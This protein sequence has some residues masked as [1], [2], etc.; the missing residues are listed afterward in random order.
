MHILF[1]IHIY[2][3]I[4]ICMKK[5]MN[6]QPSQAKTKNRLKLC[7]F[8]GKRWKEQQVRWATDGQAVSGEG[9][10]RSQ[11]FP[12]KT[13]VLEAGFYDG[14][15]RGSLRPAA[16]GSPGTCETCKFSG[17]H[18]F[19]SVQFSRSVVSD[20]LR[21]HESQHARPPCP[22]PTPGVHSNSCASSR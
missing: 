2:S 4:Y 19:S 5:S 13:R 11:S 16:M 7:V 20:S 14:Q 1:L 8:W 17:T 12:L 22:S 10:K 21:P 9:R 6:S 3:Y 18:Q 15:W